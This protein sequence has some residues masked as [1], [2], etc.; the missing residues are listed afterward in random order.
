[1]HQ[2]RLFFSIAPFNLLISKHLRARLSIYRLPSCFCVLCSL[3][4]IDSSV[5]ISQAMALHHE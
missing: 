4:L 5:T 1:M 2:L 3:L